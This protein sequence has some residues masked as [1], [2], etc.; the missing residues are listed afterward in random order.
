MAEWTKGEE[1]VLRDPQDTGDSKTP[2]NGEPL[3][4]AEWR[5]GPPLAKK[6]DRCK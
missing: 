2:V 1:E 6:N 5:K 3:G 4:D